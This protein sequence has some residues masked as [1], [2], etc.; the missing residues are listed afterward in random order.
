VGVCLTFVPNA[1]GT[2]NKSRKASP[3]HPN[4]DIIYIFV[5]LP[6]L[7]AAVS[8]YCLWLELKQ[9]YIIILVMRVSA[10]PVDPRLPV[11]VIILTADVIGRTGVVILPIWNA[12]LA[13]FTLLCSTR[14]VVNFF[15]SFYFPPQTESISKTIYNIISLFLWYYN[16]LWERTGF[17]LSS[18]VTDYSLNQIHQ[19]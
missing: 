17:M 5:L 8:L 10:C 2:A 7:S 12:G 15:G 6:S 9:V 14:T 18:I 16:N 1:K 13:R 11:A 4:T 3:L 19:Q